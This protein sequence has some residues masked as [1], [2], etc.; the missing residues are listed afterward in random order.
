MSGMP[1]GDAA[2][3]PRPLPLPR[4]GFLRALGGAGLGVTALGGTL[5]ACSVQDLVPVPLARA[6]DLSGTKPAVRFANWSDYVDTVPGNPPRHPTLEEFTRRTGIVMDYSEPSRR[7]SS[8][9]ARSGSRSPWAGHRAMTSSCS[10]TGRWQS[11]SS[12]VGPSSPALLPNGSRL[13]PQFRDWPVPD[14]RRFSLPWQCGFTGIVYNV[15]VTHRPVTSINDLL[16][17]PDLHGKVSLPTN[18]QDVMALVML[19]IGIIPPP[20]PIASSA[21]PWRS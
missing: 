4:R 16:T 18:Y 3:P 11:S 1:P 15:A 13:L 20:S 21:P 8:S 9:S 10:R 7:T 12:S 14:V 5:S 17:A 2:G 19:G 6:A